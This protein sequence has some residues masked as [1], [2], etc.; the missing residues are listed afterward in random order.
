MKDNKIYLNNTQLHICIEN[1]PL[2][3]V[4]LVR[5]LRQIRDLCSYGNVCTR[6]GVFMWTVPS[7]LNRYKWE[8]AISLVSLKNNMKRSNNLP[9][10]NK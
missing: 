1:T 7:L 10:V 5:F 9:T 2:Y 6:Q 8:H 4:K 3:K